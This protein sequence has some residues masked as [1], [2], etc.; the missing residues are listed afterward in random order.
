M[1]D[2]ARCLRRLASLAGVTGQRGDRF[3]WPAVEVSVGLPLP[4]DYKALLET[5]PDGTFGGLIRPNRPGDD[6]HQTTEFLGYYAYR[7]GDMREWREAGYGTY[8]YP[9]FPEPGGVLPWAT[10]PRGEP[11]CWL[12][13]DDDPDR[14][15]VILTDAD[16]TRWHRF[17]GSACEF[18]L[19]L[20]QGRFDAGDSGLDLTVKGPS[21]TPR[22]ANAAAAA[23]TRPFFTAKADVDN[24]FAALAEALGRP[25][26]EPP[27]VDWTQVEQ[28]IAAQLPADYKSFID[29]YGPGRYCDISI[30][31][32]FVTLRQ[33]RYQQLRDPARPHF[34]PPVHPEP[35]GIIAWGET[36]DGW[37]LW[38]APTNADPDQWGI[39]IVDP[40][41]RLV[42]HQPDV[43]FSAFLLRYADPEIAASAITG[44]DPWSGEPRFTPRS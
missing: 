35:D 9:I 11:I 34:P 14:W 7:L 26:V 8:P 25:P 10:G 39:V 24:E 22:N 40:D 23:P 37:T 43:S 21:F 20:V 17:P 4:G 32:D 31:R 41:I 36:N 33:R 44:R 29:T 28:Q 13:E 30:E 15:P 3:D 18:L 5:F 38:W 16:F 19:D 42:E 6:G 27:P 1:D 12:T 2:K